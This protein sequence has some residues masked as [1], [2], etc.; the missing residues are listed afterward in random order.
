[1]TNRLGYPKDVVLP[2][3]AARKLKQGQSQWLQCHTTGIVATTWYDIKPI[4]FL[5]NAVVAENS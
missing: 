4:Y 2:K 3:A 1:M 5:F